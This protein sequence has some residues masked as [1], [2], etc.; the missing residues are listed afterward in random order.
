MAIVQP[1][2]RGRMRPE[3]PDAVRAAAALL[4]A[5][6]RRHAQGPRGR[7]PRRARARSQLHGLPEGPVPHGQPEAHGRPAGREL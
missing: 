2:R 6:G 7:Q 3:Q 1:R 4:Q 5:V